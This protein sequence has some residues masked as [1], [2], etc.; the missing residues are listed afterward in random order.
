MPAAIPPS[1][2]SAIRY[3]GIV[4]HDGQSVV[5]REKCE[6]RNEQGLAA[7]ALGQRDLSCRAFAAVASADDLNDGRQLETGAERPESRLDAGVTEVK[8]IDGA[9]VARVVL[10]HGE[11]ALART[12]RERSGDAFERFAFGI[13]AEKDFRD[14]GRPP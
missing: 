9:E 5:Q 11:S 7:A 2:C 10:G 4:T 6:G 3:Q 13:N 14:S 1:P 8:E 12:R